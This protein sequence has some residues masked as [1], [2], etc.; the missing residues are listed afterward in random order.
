MVHQKKPFR[1]K[2][3]F[4]KSTWYDMFLFYV[5]IS[6]DNTCVRVFKKIVYTKF[7]TSSTYRVFYYIKKIGTSAS[8]MQ[9]RTLRR[10]SPK[11]RGHAVS[12]ADVRV[13][14]YRAART[15]GTPFGRPAGSPPLEML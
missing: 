5:L 13:L 11:S 8:A 10:T 3:L 4:K 12:A 6:D 15:T 7:A 9:W 2:K 14:R 1:T